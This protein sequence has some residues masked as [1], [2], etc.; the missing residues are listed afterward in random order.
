MGRRDKSDDLAS[1]VPNRRKGSR[2]SPRRNLH[3]SRRKRRRP[4]FEQVQRL[5]RARPRM[6]ARRQMDFLLQRQIRRIQT[7]HRISRYLDARASDLSPSSDPLL[8]AVWSPDSKKLLYT[9]TNLKV[10]VLDIASGQTKIVGDDPWMVPTRT[11]NPVWSPDSK[12]VAYSSRLR[13]LYHAIFISN[14]ETGERKSRS[15]TAWPIP[16]G[17]PGTP[18]ASICGFSP[19]P[20]SV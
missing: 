11:I 4:Q 5:R 9:D 6:V 17:P 20:I 19:P 16:S 1:S 15:P 3:D 14:V 18:A 2:R 8:H 7:G 13:S 12:W 10:W